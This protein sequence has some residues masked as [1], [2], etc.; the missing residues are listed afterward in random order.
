MREPHFKQATILGVGLIGASLALALKKHSIS[1][2]IIG[3]GR[4]LSN[5]KRAKKRGI[6]DSF[7]TDPIRAVINSD[8]V[9][10]STPVGLFRELTQKIAPYL[11]KGS[12]LIDVGSIKS[13]V[14]EIESLLP[15]GV[16]FVG[17]HPIA[18]GD[19]S[20]I[21]TA[22][23]EL[24]KGSLLII[25]KTER[26]SKGALRRVSSLWRAL[27]SDI[28]TMS[29]E[30]HDRVY[31]LISHLPHLV[32]YALVNTISEVDDSSI[33]FA[34]QGFRDTTRV[35]G[36]SPEIWRDIAL[37][38]RGNLIDLLEVFKS[39]IERLIDILK[40]SDATALEKELSRAQALRARLNKR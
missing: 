8:L 11:K 4:R 25:T 19:R 38:N 26:T 13:V 3:F 34:G 24:F 37:M 21:D 20:G 6:I 12:I 32:A 1:D 40:D 2:N 17:C 10:L 28:K 16:D 22:T 30:E 9:V 35:A 29:P 33:R 7:E 18:G 36:S 31:A 5:L 27:G 15:K 39:N 14:Y 23:A